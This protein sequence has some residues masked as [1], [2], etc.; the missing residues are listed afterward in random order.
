MEENDEPSGNIFQKAKHR[1]QAHQG[2]YLFISV[3][4]VF[5]GWFTTTTN[6]RIS[7]V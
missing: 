5:V 6:A 2:T 4:A 7:I 3:I 1:F